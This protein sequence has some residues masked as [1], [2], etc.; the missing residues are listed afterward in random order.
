MRGI[1]WTAASASSF[2]I[3]ETTLEAA[4]TGAGRIAP[5]RVRDG[6]LVV[7]R[8][9]AT[10]T[11]VKFTPLTRSLTRGGAD[12]ESDPVIVVDADTDTTV[13]W[14]YDE[15]THGRI[16]DVIVTIDGGPDTPTL[17]WEGGP[18]APIAAS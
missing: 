3:D 14:T 4:S 12:I 6:R 9:G 16:A 15:A 1:K 5:E 10:S 2:T 17:T 7:T 8:A 18:V 11:T 13:V